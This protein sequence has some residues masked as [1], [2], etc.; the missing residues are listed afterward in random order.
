MPVFNASII[1]SIY[2]AV[3]NG[4]SPSEEPIIR[5]SVDEI[6][7]KIA[8]N[9][10]NV[11]FKKAKTTNI[12]YQEIFDHSAASFSRI[13]VSIFSLLVEKF[14][15][16]YVRNITNGN[17][18]GQ[19]VAKKVF[20]MIFFIRRINISVEEEAENCCLVIFNGR[21]AAMIISLLYF[22]CLC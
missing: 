14:S 15:L 3:E 22:S 18:E 4:A 8:S 2:Q 9:P 16:G 5:G 6:A 10:G 20:Q 13:I 19:Y 12:L 1:N 7:D 21:P 17:K 11:F